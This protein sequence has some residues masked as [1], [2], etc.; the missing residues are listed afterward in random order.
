LVVHDPEAREILEL[1][2]INSK[3][4]KI[5]GDFFVRNGKRVVLKD[6]VAR[7]GDAEW[8]HGSAVRAGAHGV[9]FVFWLDVPVGTELPQIEGGQWIRLLPAPR[10]LSDV[11]PTD[12][13]FTLRHL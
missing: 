3:A 1:E 13:N 2:F 6:G 9:P 8:W 12:A 10:L 11:V 7:M 4:I 5:N